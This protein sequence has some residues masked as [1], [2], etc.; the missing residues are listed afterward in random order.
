MAIPLR[1][2]A[3]EGL[4]TGSIVGEGALSELLAIVT[5]LTLR[6]V[7]L[8]PFD[9]PLQAESAAGVNVDDLLIVEAEP[10]P[11]MPMQPTL[12]EVTLEV[13]P[14]RVRGN[15]ATIPGFDPARALARP[16]GPFVALANATIELP[17]GAG[18]D[19]IRHDLVLVNRYAVERV[20][21]S[22]ELGFFFPGAHEQALT[23][24]PHERG[25]AVPAA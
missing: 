23:A 17:A 20:D 6:D 19:T 3:A 25:Q 12:H 14:Y 21:S 24:P 11:V 7:S 13:G 10:R 4:L 16:T 1:A 9:G 5:T 8:Q 18:Q 2:Y 22:L 15:L